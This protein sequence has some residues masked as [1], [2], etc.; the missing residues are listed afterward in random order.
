M[1]GIS[2]FPTVQ[3]MK[4]RCVSSHCRI[5]AHNTHSCLGSPEPATA[6]GLCFLIA[7]PGIFKRPSSSGA[8]V[9]D[10]ARV[11]LWRGT[12]PLRGLLGPGAHLM[13]EEAPM[14]SCNTTQWFPAQSGCQGAWL[15]PG[16][17]ADGFSSCAWCVLTF[18]YLHSSH[19]P[20]R[21]GLRPPKN[22]TAQVQ[23]QLS[24]LLW[25]PDQ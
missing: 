5:Q 18:H 19:G 16:H 2:G 8:R 12:Q 11:P 10:T 1:I 23:I 22:V 3:I 20:S 21:T 13:P 4:P 7:Q 24:P 9:K 25:S 6:L 14:P 15:H 17:T